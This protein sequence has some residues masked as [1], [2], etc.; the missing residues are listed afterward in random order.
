MPT[1]THT[2]THIHTH[3]AEVGDSVTR[4]MSSDPGAAAQSFSARHS[5]WTNFAVFGLIEGQST[6]RTV[7]RGVRL[8]NRSRRQGFFHIKPCS[9]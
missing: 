9:Y 2:D 3:E 7:P 8:K 1:N 4:S 6:G 5:G